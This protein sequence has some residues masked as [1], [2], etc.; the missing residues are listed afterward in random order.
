MH[1]KSV[2]YWPFYCLL[3]HYKY[4]YGFEIHPTTNIAPGFYLG[5][6]GGVVINAQAI[7]GYNVNIAQ[8]VTIGSSNRG[9]KC[10]VPIIK[11]SVWI[12]PGAKIIGN[13]TVG[14]NVLMAPNAVVVDD[15]KDNCCV[16]GIPAKV[17]SDRGARKDYIQNPIDIDA[18][19]K[20]NF[21]EDNTL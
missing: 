11:N 15:V 12:G 5:H 2:L 4:K 21:I 7:I 8:G 16:G 1:R 6:F 19:E 17:I 20:R 18:Y 13:L 10:G 9:S 14:D 3:R